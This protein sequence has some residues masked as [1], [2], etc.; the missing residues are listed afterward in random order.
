M[1]TPG[2]TPGCTSGGING[3]GS[4]RPLVASVRATAGSGRTIWLRGMPLLLRAVLGAPEGPGGELPD[5]VCC[6]ASLTVELS[7]RSRDHYGTDS[8]SLGDLGTIALTPETFPEGKIGNDS[9]V[10]PRKYLRS[11]ASDPKSYRSGFSQIRGLEKLSFPCSA[12]VASALSGAVGDCSSARLPVSS[13]PVGHRQL[14]FPEDLPAD[15]DHVFLPS[16]E[17][18]R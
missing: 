3:R 12:Q 13:G 11:R 2:T 8:L 7:F 14:G 18:P 6:S 4:E 1:A 15:L 17:R 9:F 10:P 5:S 16:L